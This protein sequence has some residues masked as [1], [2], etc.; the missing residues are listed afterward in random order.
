MRA[1]IGASLLTGAPAR[2]S[3]RVISA[4]LNSYSAWVRSSSAAYMRRSAS[5]CARD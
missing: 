3:W 1:L 2:N 5:S 4:I